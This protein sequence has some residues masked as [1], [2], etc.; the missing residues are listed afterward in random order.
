MVVDQFVL[1]ATHSHLCLP[2]SPCNRSILALGKELS[3][4]SQ[5]FVYIGNFVVQSHHNLAQALLTK[6]T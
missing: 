4:Y 5:I 1:R 2:H 3:S 6:R